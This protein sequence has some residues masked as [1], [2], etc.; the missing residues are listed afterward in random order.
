MAEVTGYPVPKLS[1]SGPLLCQR[2]CAENDHLLP[3]RPAGLHT[4]FLSER[5]EQNIFPRLLTM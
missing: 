1:A 3:Q 2:D 4:G 5:N